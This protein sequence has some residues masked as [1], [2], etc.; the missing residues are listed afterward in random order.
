MNYIEK[1]GIVETPKVL[2]EKMLDL[3]DE[4]LFKDPNVRW[5]DT[6]AGAGI[7]ASC[8]INRL[9]EENADRVDLIEVN[10]ELKEELYKKFK[11]VYIEDYLNFDRAKYEVIIGNPPYNRNNLKKVPTNRKNSKPDDGQTLWMNFLYK[12]IELLKPGGTLCYIIPSIWMKNNHIVYKDLI[13]YDIKYVIPYNSSESNKI[14]SGNCHMS[15]S[16]LVLEKNPGTGIVNIYDKIKKD[17]VIYDTKFCRHLPLI[18][19]N[20]VKY[21]YELCDKY[22]S[23]SSYIKKSNV[24]SKKI[25]VSKEKTENYKFKNVETCL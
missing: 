7:F 2:V 6:G 5:L 13:K 1:H 25:M 14:F 18:G 3:I 12:S 20:L 21:M 4:K 19:V 8:V 10:D 9:G 17:F 24:I 11:N 23:I 16:I 22:G 15:T